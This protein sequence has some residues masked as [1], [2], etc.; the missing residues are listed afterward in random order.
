M[1]GM[2]LERAREDAGSSDERGG[3]EADAEA[4][5]GEAAAGTARGRARGTAPP[6]ADARRALVEQ[7]EFYFGD[8]NVVTDEW[9]RERIR[10]AEGGWVSLEEVCAFPRMR[11]KLKRRSWKEVV[12]GAIREFGSGV[13]ELSEDGERVRRLEPVPEFDAEEIERR[14]VVAENCAEWSVAAL[15]EIFETCGEVTNVRVRK[16][17]HDGIPATENRGKV[18]ALVEFASIE[19]ANEAATRLDNPT[20]WRN[21]IR[22]RVLLKPGQKKKQN[23]KKQ[24]QKVAADTEGKEEADG[25]EQERES[26]APATKKATKKKAKPDYAKWASAAA[27]KENRTSI[28]PQANVEKAGEG[29]LEAVEASI[30]KKLVLTARVQTVDVRPQPTMPDGSPGFTRKRTCAPKFAASIIS[31]TNG[32]ED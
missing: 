32:A 9:L 10:S 22:V 27:F 18:H 5:A 19:Q 12:P 21:G 29:E 8:A 28:T 13:I 23:K 1:R 2:S 30:P 3:A 7:L 4:D 17:G 6:R 31:E 16:P 26:A 20:D 14:T 15:R 11:S 25:Q 24:A